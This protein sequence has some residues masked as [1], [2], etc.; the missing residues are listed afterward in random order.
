M[1]RLGVVAVADQEVSTRSVESLARVD[2]AGDGT[3][4]SGE[5]DGGFSLG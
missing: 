1:G 2:K 4:K 5:V 3:G